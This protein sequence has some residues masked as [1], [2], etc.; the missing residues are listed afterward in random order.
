MGE[1]FAGPEKLGLNFPW[2]V[3]CPKKD[4]GTVGFFSF[5]DL[6]M[7]RA[8]TKQASLGLQIYIQIKTTDH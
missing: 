6:A 5:Q 1:V 4:L 3:F 8:I 7:E 2:C